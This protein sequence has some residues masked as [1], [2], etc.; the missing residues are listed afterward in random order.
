[1]E[2]QLFS[3]VSL[4]EARELAQFP[5]LL[6]TEIPPGYTFNSA[7]VQHNS[8]GTQMVS[9]AYASDGGG[10]SFTQVAAEQPLPT[11]DEF[12]PETISVRQQEA[13]LWQDSVGA[14]AVVWNENGVQMSVQ[15]TP[16]VD[17]EPLSREA[18]LLFAESL[19]PAA[20]VTLTAAESSPIPTLPPPTPFFEPTPD[21]SGMTSAPAPMNLAAVALPNTFEEALDVMARMPDEVAGLARGQE[22]SPLDF[23]PLLGYGIRQGP[24]GVEMPIFALNILNVANSGFFPANWGGGH[25]VAGPWLTGSDE[26]SKF[27]RE[28]DLVWYQSG[29]SISFG[30]ED[31]PLAFILWAD[32]PENLEALL[33]AFVTATSQ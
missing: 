23:S 20:E 26:I 15:D 11:W 31:S 30:Y 1:M 10:L 14:Y 25:V 29:S 27:G 16:Y 21:L 24:D 12:D 13:R 19:R 4:A 22:P 17:R 3:P 28:G 2:S 9:I 33:A 7:S 8:A 6:P 18:V 32:S 5:L